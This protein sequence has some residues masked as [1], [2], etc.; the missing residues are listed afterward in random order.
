MK[1]HKST[2]NKFLA[3]LDNEDM[4]YYCLDYS[5]L[6]IENISTKNLL[7]DLLLC[8]ELEIG[9]ALSKP[10]MNV[11]I[12]KK[13]SQTVFILICLSRGKRYK[14]RYTDSEKPAAAVMVNDPNSLISLYSV[15]KSN[16][17]ECNCVTLNDS[18]RYLVEIIK[19]HLD[20]KH[21]TALLSEFGE[22]IECSRLVIAQL[23]EHFAH[24]Q[25]Y[26]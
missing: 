25:P 5:S 17:L 4:K 19:N 24:G 23:K 22:P 9:E 14:L 20:K 16:E 21:L 7:S 15:L 13:D 1:I 11:D 6:D 2:K 8:S 18:S 26:I 12:I 10:K 3:E